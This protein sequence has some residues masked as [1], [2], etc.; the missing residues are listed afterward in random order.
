MKNKW[1]VQLQEDP[2][3]GDSILEFP[4]DVLQQ[5]GWKEG[6]SLNWKDNGDGSFTLTKKETQWVLVECVGTFRHRYMVEVPTGKEL[7]AL[8]TVTMNEA[9][10]FSQEY[11]GE[12]IVS[13]RVV[14]YDEAMRMCDA[15]NK[16]VSSWNSELKTKTFFTTIADQENE[17]Y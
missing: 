15:D 16:Y 9:K 2:E 7:W 8:D 11:L 10:E 12:Q 1:T 14:S 13:H 4:P 3:T 6:D 5:V 17:H